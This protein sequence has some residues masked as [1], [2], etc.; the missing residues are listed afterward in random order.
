LV[1]VAAVAV[2]ATLFFTRGGSSNGSSTAGSG[3]AGS[4]AADASGIASA[5][6][7]GPVAIITEDLTC[8]PWTPIQNTLA[9]SEKNGW[10]DRDPSIP[11]S[12][13]KPEQRAQYQAVG[14]AMR[15]AAD[16]TV[17]LVKLTPH[18]VMRELYEQM[19]AYSRAYAEHIPIYT[20]PDD[21]L[22]RTASAAAAV[23]G[24]VCDAISYGSAA[25][26]GPLVRASASPAQ[27]ASPGDPAHPKRF[28]TSFDPVCSDWQTATDQFTADTADWAKI[29]PDTSA[30]QWTPEQKAINEAVAPAMSAS[31]DTLE[32]LG[33]RNANP[34]LQ[35]FATLAAQYRR[36][37]V[38][39]LPTYIPADN[40][41]ASAALYASGV[42]LGACKA[43]EVS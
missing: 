3:S 10:L 8:A 35:D 20:P 36:A 30:S 28:L 4:D 21:S 29:S 26:R 1:A 13:W 11:A 37:Y 17:A 19:I 31:A 40:Y 42:V 43:V 32:K 16:Q 23:L 7:T 5:N 22:A 15:S 14:Q 25:A 6:D 27:T 38:A 39:A 9:A 2:A 24:N 33:R 18:R 41:L 34:T 12:A